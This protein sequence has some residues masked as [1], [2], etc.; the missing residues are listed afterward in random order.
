MT[1]TV[2]PRRLNAGITY[3]P[4]PDLST[5][6]SIER[7]LG[8]SEIQIK[9]GVQYSLNSMIN[10]MMGVQANPNRLGIGAK[11]KYSRKINNI[12]HNNISTARI[13]DINTIK[14]NW[15]SN[16][17]L[18]WNTNIPNKIKRINAPYIIEYN[19]IDDKFNDSQICWIGKA[20]INNKTSINNH[21][22]LSCINIFKNLNILFYNFNSDLEV[23]IK[24]YIVGFSKGTGSCDITISSVG[25][26]SFTIPVALFPLNELCIKCFIHQTIS[27]FVEF[28]TH[29]G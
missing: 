23:K 26:H 14:F 9:G 17:D 11:F 13:G 24:N 8:R 22:K 21:K 25:D 20:L 5:A 6:I 12:N 10:L 27:L 29:V 19:F 4:M 16:P 7:L 1:R 18:W 28:T 2:L 3:L 15:F